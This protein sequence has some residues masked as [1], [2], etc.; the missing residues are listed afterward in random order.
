MTRKPPHLSLS[1]YLLRM[2]AIGFVLGTLY[3]LFF[4]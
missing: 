4:R 2:A 3:G 1:D